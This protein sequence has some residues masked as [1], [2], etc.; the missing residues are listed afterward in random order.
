MP[1]RIIQEPFEGET[2]DLELEAM[3]LDFVRLKERHTGVYLAETVQLIVEKF[4]VKNKICGIVTD[5][6][7]NNKTMID[8]IRKYKWPRFKGKG[9]WVRCFAH[10]LN[11]IVQVILRPFGSHKKKASSTSRDQQGDSDDED[12]PDD[13]EDQI[14]LF[15]QEGG[16]GDEED[17]D[18]PG[19]STE[20]AA[21]LIADDEIE[22]ENDD[23]NELSDE[24]ETD[25]YTSESCK[26]T[27]AKFRAIARK[28]NK[29]PNF[30]SLFVQICREKA[31][32]RPY[33]VERDVRTRW[34][35]T[36]GQLTGIC[37]CL[38]AI[39]ISATEP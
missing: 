25:R 15:N 10:I 34:N 24:E 27:L 18:E 1:T 14:E 19:N 28:L 29:S 3:P 33:N 12:D 6:A 5:N 16:G 26:K 17:E 21:E 8:E 23:V 7:S 11:L 39:K 2:G 35:S 37:R 38:A 32:S 4:G 9:Q 36:L 13:A 30:K 20:L 22:L 31:C